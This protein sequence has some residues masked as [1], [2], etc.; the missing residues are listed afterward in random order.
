MSDPK[1]AQ[2]S[3]KAIADKLHADAGK[4]T[5]PGASAA[6]KKLGDDYDSLAS[7]LTTG[8]MPD[9]SAIM[10]DATTMATACVG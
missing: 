5:K 6:I 7:A 4:A 10:N 2:S 3:I 8:K 1:S 9:T